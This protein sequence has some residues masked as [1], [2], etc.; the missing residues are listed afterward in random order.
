MQPIVANRAGAIFVRDN[1]GGW[2]ATLN[3]GGDAPMR[4]LFPTP[5]NEA[6]VWVMNRVTFDGYHSTDGGRTWSLIGT[7]QNQDNQIWWR[8]DLGRLFFTTGT[9]QVQRSNDLG[10]TMTPLYTA[11]G[12]NGAKQMALW[13]NGVARHGYLFWIPESGYSDPPRG[14]DV[15]IW[16]SDRDGDFSWDPSGINA[17][18][19]LFDTFAASDP[20]LMT[21]PAAE[22]MYAYRS[23]VSS[24]DALSIAFFGPGQRL[25]TFDLS[26]GLGGF[27]RVFPTCRA[28]DMGGRVFCTV[29]PAT[30]TVGIAHVTTADWL[31]GSIWRSSDSGNTWSEIVSDTAELSLR[32]PGHFSANLL[33][34]SIAVD[35]TDPSNIWVAGA[36]P[37]VYHSTDMGL[38]WSTETLPA[39]AS[40]GLVWADIAMVP[41]VA[42]GR[43]RVF[44]QVIG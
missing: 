17:S 10:V 20:M 1:A 4:G 31:L 11:P 27:P 15:T 30:T 12:G 16:E 32:I 33:G 18:I 44:A 40:S 9:N 3:L 35:P 5:G 7:I 24:E 29:M 2:T 13:M 39:P 38:T 26:V 6:D 42:G 14:N 28:V 37:K 25:G 23:G 36:P 43:G 19:I 8:D 41:G 21:Q 34:R 22:I